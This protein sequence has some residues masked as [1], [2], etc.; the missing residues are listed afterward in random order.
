MEALFCEPAGF[1]WAGFDWDLGMEAVRGGTC[2]AEVGGAF[3]ALGGVAPF[4]A[5]ADLGGTELAEE[6]GEDAVLEAEGIDRE[7]LVLGLRTLTFLTEP[8]FSGAV[9]CVC[10]VGRCGFLEGIP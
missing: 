7:P 8:I 1:D 5:L 3:A 6:R 10:V 9:L 2:F 4:V